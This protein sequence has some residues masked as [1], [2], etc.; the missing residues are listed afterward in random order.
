VYSDLVTSP[1]TDPSRLLLRSDAAYRRIR[2]MI[3]SGGLE[4]GSTVSEAE[5][6]RQL[7]MSRTPVREALRQLR[8]E[9]LLVLVPGVG[10]VVT[11]LSDADMQNLYM[12]RA[13]LEGLAA[14]LAAARAGRSDI[15]RLEDLYDEMEQAHDRHDDVGLA[16]L[17]S[18]FHDA[19]AR[20]SGN[21]Y[22][23]RA[24][25]DARETFERYRL[26]A[27]GKPGRRDDAHTEHGELIAALKA[28]DG[29]RARELAT[30]HVRRALDVRLGRDQMA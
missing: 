24:L 1:S 18:Q 14:E 25:A 20:A 15:A 17:N 16:R 29:D 7:D 22:L 9:R 19:V 11:E 5:L 27:L 2:D 10:Y 4:A 3:M 13:V 30:G 21:D 23:Q 8:A 6:V 26:A 28:R 12:V